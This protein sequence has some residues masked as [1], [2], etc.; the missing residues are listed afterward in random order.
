MLALQGA[1]L[2]LHGMQVLRRYLSPDAITVYWAILL[3]EYNKHLTLERPRLPQHA[4]TCDAAAKESR[5]SCPFCEHWLSCECATIV[6]YLPKE[7]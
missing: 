4:C 5:P 6:L 1:T 3:R 2:A 7:L